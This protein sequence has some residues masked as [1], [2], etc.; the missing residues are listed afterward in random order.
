MVAF[1]AYFHL[2]YK[3]ERNWRLF[4]QEMD[5]RSALSLYSEDEQPAE[6]IMRRMHLYE[7]EIQSGAILLTR[8]NQTRLNEIKEQGHK[9][10][11]GWQYQTLFQ[12]QSLLELPG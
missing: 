7:I 11:A 5:I 3:F 1:C 12:I 6:W 10:D 2:N 8:L 9:D 4:Q